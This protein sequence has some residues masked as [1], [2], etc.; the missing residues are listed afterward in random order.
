MFASD[1]EEI[2]GRVVSNESDDITWPG[3][4]FIYARNKIL[5]KGVFPLLFREKLRK[6]IR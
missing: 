3:R 4:L 1:S 2:H 6:G 5:T